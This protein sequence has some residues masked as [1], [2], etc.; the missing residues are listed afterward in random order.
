MSDDSDYEQSPASLTRCS[1]S[2]IIPVM[3]G[4][5]S[6]L[7]LTVCG[8]FAFQ[9]F[10][11]LQASEGKMKSLN[12]WTESFQKKAEI[13]TE[14]QKVLDQSKENLERL[15]NQN[16]YLTEALQELKTNQGDTCESPLHHWIQY[17]D[18]CYHQT[19]EMVSWFNCSDLCVSLNA[20]FVKTE[21][22]GLISFLKLFVAN[23]T[24]LGLSYEEED[25][26]WRW[27]N[28]SSLSLDLGLPAPRV[29]FQGKCVHLKAHT[30]GIDNCST[31]SSCMCE[32]NCTNPREEKSKEKL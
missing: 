14:V 4:I 13:F 8:F 22:S 23:H 7:L 6:L 31:S 28:G 20:T 3:L 27:E 10:Q 25:N 17:T 29:D 15:Q 12:L 32:R 1:L 9:Y 5:F 21:S 30:I 19:M 11:S 2:G 24:W 16:V 26:Q 18:H